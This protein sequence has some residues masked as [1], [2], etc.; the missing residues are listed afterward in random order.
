MTAVLKFFGKL[1]VFALVGMMALVVALATIEL[2][3]IIV[4]DI[5]TPPIF[6]LDSNELLDIFGLFLLVLVG[7]ELLDTIKTYLAKRELH[8]EVVLLVA[9]IAVAR[10]VIIL[11]EAKLSAPMLLGIAAIIGA[12]GISYYLLKLSHT[13]SARADES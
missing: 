7:I 10:K 11:D 6:L 8:T 3:W 1:I 4:K 9:M 2:G 12:L 5:I 13:N